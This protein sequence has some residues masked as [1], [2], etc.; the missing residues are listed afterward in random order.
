MVHISLG[1]YISEETLNRII[2]V[3]I[4]SQNF[5]HLFTLV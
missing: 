4:E 3:D 5:V 1:T 2:G